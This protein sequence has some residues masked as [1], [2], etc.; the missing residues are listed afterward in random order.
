MLV[1]RPDTAAALDKAADEIADIREAQQ[2]ASDEDAGSTLPRSASKRSHED[3]TSRA[4][5]E[6]A[7]PAASSEN[8]KANHQVFVERSANSS[9]EQAN[10]SAQRLQVELPLVIVETWHVCWSCT[11]VCHPIGGAEWKTPGAVCP[12]AYKHLVTCFTS[13]SRLASR[14]LYSTLHCEAV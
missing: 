13:T 14:T 12:P 11:A 1:E 4:E 3:L 10:L 9:F 6:E 8:G 5:G 7:P 2:H